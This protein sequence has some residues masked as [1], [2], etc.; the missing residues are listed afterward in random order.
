MEATAEI[1][2]R[3]LMSDQPIVVP[4]DC[5]V[6][7]VLRVMN[8][9]RIGAVMVSADGSIDGIFSE[10]DF[11]RQAVE[12]PPGWRQRPVSDWMTRDPHVIDPEAG[13]EEAVAMMEDKHVRHLPV[14]ENGQIIGIVSARQLMARRNEHLNRIVDERTEQLQRLFDEVSQ[15]DAEM[16]GNMAV[17]G[18]LQAR[19]LLPGAPPGWPE[20]HWGLHYS[21]L[22]PLGGDYYDFAVRDN[23]MGI[24]IADASGH[25][26][27]AAMVAIMARF[28]FAEVVRHSIRPAEVLSFMNRRLQ[29]LTDERFVTAFY[30]LLDRKTREFRY[31]NAG[32]LPA[33]RF[34]PKRTHVEE[35]ATRGLMLGIMPNAVYE[36]KALVLEPGDRLCLFT[37]GVVDSRRVTKD[38]FGLDR[39]KGFLVEHAHLSAAVLTQ[40]LVE[41]LDD[42]RSD[43]PAWDDLT[44]LIAE[45]T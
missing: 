10:R 20:I 4:P 19:L 24:L 38:T 43:M 29:G 14:V 23:Q 35:L 5:P 1:T 45:V 18:R 11:L 16:R 21:P 12:A 26:V 27:S 15:R 32:H 31:A 6:Q 41:R 2:V 36:E 25:S 37:D 44:I 8:E 22:D 33:L 28:A 42:F 39:L 13:W 9:E 34:N 7:D 17:A 3:D 30:G 40:A